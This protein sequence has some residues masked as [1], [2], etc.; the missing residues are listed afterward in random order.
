MAFPDAAMEE[1]PTS[2][3]LFQLWMIYSAK[4]DVH[5]LKE[6]LA[7]FIKSYKNLIDYDFDHLD[8]VFSDEGPH[9]T[10]LPDGILQVFRNHLSQTSELFA[11]Q[12][13]PSH[14]TLAKSILQCLIVICRNCDNV[15]MVASCGF[16]KYIVNIG[17]T[18]IE[19]MSSDLPAAETEELSTFV[20]LTVHFFECLYD[21]FFVWRRRIREWTVDRSRIKCRPASLHVEVVPYFYDCCERGNFNIDLK[22]R[23]LHM[24]GAIMCGDQSNALKVIT[25]ATLDVLLKMLAFDKK[26]GPTNEQ[27]QELLSL[28]DLVLKS[29]IC[30]V[31]MIHA[32]IPDQRQVEVSQ[33]MEGYMQVLLEND[34]EPEDENET[35]MQIAMIGAINEMLACQD[36]SALQVIMVSG[37]TFDAFVSLLQK[38]ALTGSEAQK[39]A[40]SV[41]RV[42]STVLSG[43]VNAKERFQLRVGYTKFVEALKSLG[44]PSIELLRAVLNLVV[45]GEFDE[46]KEHNV[47]N[48]QAAV[49]LLCWLPDIQSHDLQIWLSESLSKLCGKGHNNK[50]N[51]CNDGMISAILTV[52]GRERQINQKAVGHLISLLESLGTQSITATELKQLIGLLRLDEE[53]KQNPYCS[54]LMHAISTM[55]R[56]EGK[57]GALHFFN[58]Q[59]TTDCITLPSFRKWPGAGFSFLTWICLDST[60]DT[61]LH[62]LQDG[63]SYRRIL[64]SFVSSAGCGFEAFVTPTFDIV[65]AVYNRKEYS[66]VIVTET[67]LHDNL[68]HCIAVVHTS[69]RRP[70]TNSQLNVY[71]DGRLKLNSQLKSPNMTEAFTS[72]RVG[73]PCPRSTMNLVIDQSAPATDTKTKK[74]PLK[75]FFPSQSKPSPCEPGVNSLLTGTQDDAW[76]SPIPIHGQLGLICFFHDALHPSQIK[77]FFSAGPN[78]QTLF[79]NEEFSE[80]N[81]LVSKMVLHYDAKASKDGLCVDLSQ[82][83]NHGQIIGQRCVTWDIKDVINCI[84]GIQVLIPLLEQVNKGP[85]PGEAI[86]S[87]PPSPGVMSHSSSQEQDDWVVIPSSSYA[88]AKLEQNQVSGFL[89]LLRHMVHTKSMNQDTFV[90]TGAATTLGALLQ[91]VDPKLID[92]NVLMAVQ[93]L[94][95]TTMTVN[96]SMVNHLYQHILFDFRIWSKSDFPVR[97][98]HIQYLSTIIKD[99]RKYFRKKFGVQYILDVVRTYYSSC[100]SGLSAVDAKTIRGSLLSLVKYYMIKD[101]TAEEVS[102]IICFLVTVKEED[103][104]CEALDM[105]IS[106]LDIQKRQDQLYLLLFEPDMAELL[107]GLL[108][109]GGYSVMFY[110]KIIKVLYTILKSDKVY[111]KSKVRVRLNDCGHLGLVGMMQDCEASGPMMKRFIDQ[112]AV[113]DSPHCCNS[114]LALLQLIY[115]SSSDIKLEASRQILALLVGKVNAAKNFSK[116]L[117]WQEALTKLF[118]FRSTVNQP[119]NNNHDSIDASENPVGKAT[120][121]NSSSVNSRVGGVKED[122][123]TQLSVNGTPKHPSTLNLSSSDFSLTPT[124]NTPRTP[125]FI[126]QRQ[127]EDI[128]TSEDERPRSIS[129]SSSAS[130]E[131]LNTLGQRSQ[132]RAGSV[133]SQSALSISTSDSFISLTDN[134]DGVLDESGQKAQDEVQNIQQALDNLGIQK[135]YVRHNIERAEELSQNLLIILLSIMWKGVEGSDKAA[136]KERGQVFSW[137]DRIAETHELLRSPT[138]LKRRLLEMMLH[139]CTSDIRDAGQAVAG[140]TENAIELVRLVRHFMQA[141]MN[142]LSHADDKFTERLIEDTMTLLDIL[143][144]W[145]VESDGG[146]KEMARLGLNLLILFAKHPNLELCAVATAKL[147]NLVQ[148]KLISSSAEAS[149]IIGNL[150]SIIVKAVTENTDNYSFLIPV[151]KALIDKAYD[152]LNLDLHLP[153]LPPTARSPTFFDDFRAYCLTDEW[154]VFVESYVNP[155]MNHF[156]ENTF[157][158]IEVETKDFWSECEEAMMV[159]MHKRNRERGDSKLKFQSQIMEPFKSKTSH[160]IRRFQNITTQLRNQQLST[161]R[162][163]RAT[164]LF[165]TGERGA[166]AD[167]NIASN[168]WKLSN[169]ENFSRMKVKL[170]PNHNF[171]LHIEAAMLR[172]NQGVSETDDS[173][174][175]K[176]MS[177]AK[178]ALVSKENIADDTITDEEWNV[179]SSQGPS[180]HN[181]KEKLVHSEECE[182]VT[183]VD[184]IK[185]RL[186]VT[187][188]HV[189]FFDCS[190]NKEEGGEDFKWAVSK[191][192]EIHF[193]RYNL[194]RSALELFLVDQTNYFLNFQPKVR[195][196]VYSRILSLRPPN[197]IYFGSRSPAELLKSSGLTQKWVQREISNFDYLIQLNT[198]AG[199]TYNDLSQYP[200]FPWILSDYTSETLDLDNPTVFRDLSKPIGAVN[201]KST[202]NVR[203]KFETFEDPSGVIEKFHYG[204]HYSNAAGVMHYMIRMEPF[205]GL[206]IQLQS[207]RFDVAD[208]Q[209]H[210]V[211][212]TW[213]SLMDNPNDVK[214]LIPEF[215]Y[216]PDF[217]VNNNGFDLGLL[218]I[219]RDRVDNVILP[220]WAKSPEDF[221][222]K[223]KQAL[224]CEHVSSNL[225]NWIDLIFGYKQKGPAAVEALNVFY[226]CTYEGAVDLDAIKDPRE[227]KALEGMI[228]NFGQTPCQLLKES[229]PRR[230]SFDEMVAKSIK[231]DKAL[232]VFFFLNQLKVFFVEVS[233]E[234]D[235]LVYIS[236]P[237]NQARSIIQHGM[238]DTMVTVSEEGIVGMHGWLPYDK[239]ISNYFTFDKDPAIANSKVKRRVAGPFAPGVKVEA[240]LFVVSHDAKLLFSGGH[241]DNSLQVYHLGKGKKINHVVRHIDIVTCLALDYCGSHLITGS[242]DTTCMIWQIQQ[243]GGV[244][245]GINPNP[246]QTLYGHDAEVTAVHISTELDMAVSAA[247]DGTVIVHTVRKGHYMRTLRPPCL[248]GYTLNIPM[249]VVDETGHI[250]LYCHET[251]PIDPK[252]RFSIHLYSINGK[253]L[254]AEKLTYG[255]GHMIVSGEHLITGDTQGNLSVMEIFALKTLNSLPLHVPIHCIAITTSGSHILVGLRDG[256]LIIIG[257]KNK[258]DLRLPKR[259][260]LF[261]L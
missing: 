181:D 132:D 109:K 120:T 165:F 29:I 56:R 240:K 68:W 196:K 140:P 169:Q 183:L 173:E 104:V 180:E 13:D 162:H 212:A 126:S 38:T 245:I 23:Q 100:D 55:A 42:M 185:G 192:R 148:T 174:Q 214:E 158:D 108:V 144:V 151:L 201:A 57:E 163:W 146:W 107:L 5:T 88:D 187:T 35:R 193:R 14:L 252:E 168:Q 234:T 233:M 6:F 154:T 258:S 199:R 16:V 95:E 45:E 28:K 231:M 130:A 257:V 84:G 41:L 227:R 46:T 222:W 134:T 137:I 116:Q 110:E 194:R 21:P 178:E 27:R 229:H 218:Q 211:V 251:F 195:N 142:L 135:I 50:M 40:M 30:M 237:R 114:L 150:H 7:L 17:M 254:F 118:I 117:G 219:S 138:E 170:V 94:V 69:S 67:G 59:E 131:D 80:L 37:G 115:Y 103:L 54:R 260:P 86:M 93:L 155:Q 66:T 87:P 232:N 244:S 79:A 256:K 82:N 139:S 188:T 44:Q 32:A 202:E 102:S 216:L 123:P 164:R 153:N 112:V 133:V 25:P 81:D 197:L 206:H 8:E 157:G 141:D 145:D 246:L 215:Y 98:G 230:M 228:N 43:S 47:Q 176:R 147:H 128:A 127:F 97:I 172:D 190:S 161:L 204:T 22:L 175:L 83:L 236:V 76:G 255:L 250:A 75:F 24:F 106:L 33:V 3:N 171:D 99:D 48:T 53:E 96:K 89:T 49:M 189:Y 242:R 167:R 179:I 249:V 19:Q 223:H 90:R 143:S 61:K 62:S 85:L 52:L 101:V 205:T 122:S 247:K 160:E 259:K 105:L 198:I 124:P 51:C 65:I 213:S 224:E 1:L 209:F 36:K 72:C 239:S 10:R 207:G 152:L 78:H 243:Q 221:I 208:R 91:K 113:T 121:E 2:E 125:M 39:L 226:Y 156:V 217:L 26:Q 191:L 20:R 11:Q 74:S 71:I 34:M 63:T 220:T 92:V 253:H 177:V 159:N 129:R 70:F 64:Y 210:S 12:K 31:H 4:N 111:E 261:D 119:V 184:V 166:W 9:M 73:S 200:V 241:W 58:L 60:V 203:E 136:W 18:I 77:A 149:Y 182:L 225:H 238:P 235:P 186:E 15:P 248:T